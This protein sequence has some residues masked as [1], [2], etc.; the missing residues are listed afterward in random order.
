MRLRF[1]VPISLGIACGNAS[2]PNPAAKGDDAAQTGAPGTRDTA[3]PPA[4]EAPPE[5]AWRGISHVLVT[6]QSNS[7]GFAGN[8]Q[9]TTTQPFG[10]LMFDVGV[11]TARSCDP[12]GCREYTQP[13]KLLPL[14]EGDA[15]FD[16]PVETMASGL[17]NEASKLGAPGSIL[18]S[19][20][21]RSGNGYECLRKMGCAFNIAK[22]YLRPFEEALRQVGDAKAL[23]TAQGL[24]YRV[25]A[26][27]VIHGESDHYASPFPLDGVENY[28][29]ALVEWQRDYETAIRAATGQTTPIPLLASQ[30]SNWNDRPDS[31]IPRM[32]LDA[33]TGASGKVVLVGPTYML[34]FAEDCIHF[35]NHGERHLGEYFAKAY[36]RLRSGGW[37]PLRPIGATRA[38]QTVTIKFTV[39][40][41]PLVLDTEHV[42]DPGNFGFEYAEGGTTVPIAKVAVSGPDAVTLELGRAPG[43]GQGRVRYAMHATPYTCPGAEYG[44]RGNLR[45]SDTTPSMYG[46][47]L[48][49][50]AVHFDVAVQ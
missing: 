6:G 11:M 22:G 20:H 2:A 27:A 37:E 47:D 21:G 38:G 10:N 9:L 49:N 33:H 17:A 32:Q 3:K 7:I 26:I 50:W 46:Y 43:A 1:F 4:S 40:V 44:P 28:A 41:P 24:E 12:D 39:P 14:V 30:M 42:T 48:A 23:A 5:E 36:T 34:P 18:V 15:Y 13:K 19:I 35:T 16:K 25:A 45:D 29:D 8:P 31:E